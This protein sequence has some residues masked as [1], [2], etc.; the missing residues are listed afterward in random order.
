MPTYDLNEDKGGNDKYIDKSSD[1][2]IQLFNNTWL[3]RYPR[4]RKVMFG[5]GSDFK[6]D[7]S[8][9]LKYFYIEPVLTTIKNPQAS[10][11]M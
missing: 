9:L 8:P 5:N 1:R 7:F 3:N 10:A 2:V 6:L 4:P 11:P